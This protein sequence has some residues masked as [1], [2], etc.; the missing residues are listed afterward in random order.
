MMRITTAVLTMTVIV[1]IVRITI[2]MIDTVTTMNQLIGKNSN[3]KI[4]DNEKEFIY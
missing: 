3:I 2:T 4:K 1:V